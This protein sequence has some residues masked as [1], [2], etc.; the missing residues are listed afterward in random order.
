MSWEQ[1]DQYFRTRI[2]R[3]PRDN[4]GKTKY[5]PEIW[6]SDTKA[7]AAYMARLGILIGPAYPHEWKRGRRWWHRNWCYPCKRAL[8]DWPRAK[9][10]LWGRPTWQE[11]FAPPKRDN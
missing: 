6:A 5:I 7:A 1:F 4:E 10:A 2:G 11:A 8:L 3:T 9:A